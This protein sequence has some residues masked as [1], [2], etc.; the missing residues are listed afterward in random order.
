MR[1]KSALL[2][3]Y[4]TFLFAACKKQ[5]SFPDLN[6]NPQ[7]E[8]YKNNHVSSYVTYS[9][10]DGKSFKDSVLINEDGMPTVYFN[11]QT[12][13]ARTKV[14]TTNITYDSLGRAKK[15]RVSGDYPF[16]METKYWKDDKRKIVYASMG[17]GI[18]HYQFD[19]AF[20]NV[21]RVYVIDSTSPDTVND[22]YYIHHD[23]KILS[24][25]QKS[26]NKLVPVTEFIYNR[27][28]L[29]FIKSKN[30]ISYVS[31]KTG[32]IDSTSKNKIYKYYF[33]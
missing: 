19:D 29:K 12:N 18:L 28:K 6:E 16:E 5:E 23:G 20:K 11:F 31:Q 17:S 22:Y 24:I 10:R 21:K 25:S 15:Y 4:F 26:N 13:N 33:K 1:L 2:L 27:G 9:T 7:K 3:C 8:A 30:E 14:T 32:L